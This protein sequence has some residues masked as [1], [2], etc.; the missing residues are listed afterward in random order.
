[1]KSVD[2]RVMYFLIMYPSLSC[3]VLWIERVAVKIE[4]VGSSLTTYNK[5]LKKLI[6]FFIINHELHDFTR[7]T[8]KSKCNRIHFKAIY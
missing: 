2:F 1:M 3:L 8:C 5:F 6:S 4:I 7:L